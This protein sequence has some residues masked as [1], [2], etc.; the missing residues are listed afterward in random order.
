MPPKTIAAVAVLAGALTLGAGA[1]LAAGT[2]GASPAKDPATVHVDQTDGTDA[3]ET[4]ETTEAPD[5][6]ETTEA[7]DTTETTE[8]PKVDPGDQGKD[9]NSDRDNHGDEVSKAAHDK[10]EP[11]HGRHVSEAAHDRASLPNPAQH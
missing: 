2:T 10:S 1:A 6:T 5:T 3:P 8:A 7:P 9:G 4:S 11:D